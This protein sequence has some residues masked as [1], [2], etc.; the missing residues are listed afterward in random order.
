MPQSRLCIRRKRRH[1]RQVPYGIRSSIHD[2][3]R[4]QA[5]RLGLGGLIKGTV[6]TSCSIGIQGSFVG[7]RTSGIVD[8]RRKSRAASLWQSN[9]TPHPAVTSGARGDRRPR[10]AIA[11]QAKLRQIGTGWLAD[12]SPSLLL[13][14]LAVGPTSD[15]PTQSVSN[16]TSL[17]GEVCGGR[18]HGQEEFRR[19][20][21][22]CSRSSAKSRQAGA[23]RASGGRTGSAV[24]AKSG[25]RASS[26]RATT[27]VVSAASELA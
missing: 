19:R 14:M 1:H 17:R 11:H 18:A 7:V 6:S 27:C 12:A 13:D 8:L 25:R 16:T 23:P 22:D 3:T 5:V 4:W 2:R 21:S 24:K 26:V 15:C 9:S 20:D 10:A